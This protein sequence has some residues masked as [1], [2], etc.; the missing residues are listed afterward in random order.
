MAIV[1]PHILDVIERPVL[2]VKPYLRTRL[3]LLSLADE[4]QRQLSGKRLDEWQPLDDNAVHH[5]C[6]LNLAAL[7]EYYAGEYSRAAAICALEIER[8]AALVHAGRPI[9]WMF[10]AVEAHLNAARLHAFLGRSQQAVSQCEEIIDFTFRGGTLVLAGIR[11]TRADLEEG[12]S[13]TDARRPGILRR[14]DTVGP[15]AVWEA[16]KAYLLSADFAGL[17]SFVRWTEHCAPQCNSLFTSALLEARLK[18][19]VGVGKLEDA[20]AVLDS[21]IALVEGDAAAGRRV[22]LL[23][24]QLSLS[25]DAPDEMIAWVTKSAKDVESQDCPHLEAWYLLFRAALLCN[26]AQQRSLA[27]QLCSR[28]LD[29]CRRCDDQVAIVRTLCLLLGLLATSGADDDDIEAVCL[30]LEQEL[31]RCYYVAD[32]ALGFAEL[33]CAYHRRGDYYLRQAGRCLTAASARAA[34]LLESPLKAYVGAVTDRLSRA[35]PVSQPVHLPSH[36]RFEQLFRTAVDS[37]PFESSERAASEWA[38]ET[39]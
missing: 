34:L 35:V 37:N 15:V 6:G 26:M 5:F 2:L 36:D 28:A 7:V 29:L 24:A 27:Y 20:K 38:G 39:E 21:L 1:E 8:C 9:S 16:Y 33:A 13:R 23:A 14:L 19:M 10:W 22:A 4:A 30:G 25:M 3:N 32:S 12:W 11:F 17:L 18:A 31:R